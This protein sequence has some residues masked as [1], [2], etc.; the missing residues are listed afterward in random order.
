MTRLGK[1]TEKGLDEVSKAVLG[2]EFHQEGGPSKKG[3]VYFLFVDNATQY[4]QHT[5]W[6]RTSS[7]RRPKS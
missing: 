6:L 1:A 3:R 4:M 5:T 2:P 7:F